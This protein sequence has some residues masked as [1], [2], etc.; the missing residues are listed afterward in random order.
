MH[1]GGDLLAD[2]GF[3]TEL[4]VKLTGEGLLGGLSSWS[5]PRVDSFLS[6]D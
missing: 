4:F 6:C 5:S 3:D 1:G 2:G